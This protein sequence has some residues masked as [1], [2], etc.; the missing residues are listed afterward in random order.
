MFR[1]CHTH[2]ADWYDLPQKPPSAILLWWAEVPDAMVQDAAAALRRRYPTVPILGC[3]TAGMIEGSRLHSHGILAVFWFLPEKTRA[4]HVRAR[5]LASE[6]TLARKLADALGPAPTGPIIIMAEGLHLDGERLT[7]A[8]CETLPHATIVGGM[9]ADGER[10]QRTV[11]LQDTEILTDGLVAMALPPQIAAVFATGC[12]WQPM[13]PP[14]T[15]TKAEGRLVLQLDDEPALSLY[16]RYLGPHAA[17]L[18]ASG[19]HFPLLVSAPGG[20]PA[21]RSLIAVDAERHGLFFTTAIPEGSTV[22][23]M[24]ASMRDVLDAARTAA[25]Q[26]PQGCTAALMVSCVARRHVLGP[27]AEDEPAEVAATLGVPMAGWYSY[28]EIAAAPCSFRNQ[29]IC[30]TALRPR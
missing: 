13:G 16:A 29:T 15:V 10:F 24:H 17:D 18:P 7:R 1:T 27:L 21:L 6:W 28:G 3:S 5:G 9:A 8:L 14:R 23:L 12:G 11:L 2:S 25:R 4:V 22:R 19:H 30:L 20:A 26:I